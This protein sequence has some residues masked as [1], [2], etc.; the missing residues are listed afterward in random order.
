MTQLGERGIAVMLSYSGS[1]HA[2]DHDRDQLGPLAHEPFM[3]DVDYRFLPDVD[4]HLTSIAS[5]Q[6]FMSVVT[7]WVLRVASQRMPS[8]PDRR[9][10]R[11]VPVER[12]MLRTA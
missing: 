1:T 5:Q 3:R 4:Q 11:V 7:D 2:V 8:A 12:V 10:R 9:P 6:T